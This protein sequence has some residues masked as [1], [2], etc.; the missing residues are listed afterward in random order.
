MS[1]LFFFFFFF[2]SYVFSNIFKFFLPF[3][4]LFIFAFPIFSKFFFSLMPSPAFTLLLPITKLRP[5]HYY[6][7][8]SFIYSAFYFFYCKTDFNA[9]IFYLFFCGFVFLNCITLISPLIFIY[10][11]LFFL[12]STHF[13]WLFIFLQLHNS[14]FN[15]Y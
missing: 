1:S 3:F 15:S 4:I 5:I 8:Y 7:I 2:C 13:L 12:I 11:F 10:Y 9:F 6:V 14:D